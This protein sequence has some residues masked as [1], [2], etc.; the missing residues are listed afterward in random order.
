MWQL[1]FLIFFGLCSGIVIAGGVT[2]L[3]IGLS[4]VPR[5]A[6][7]TH[8]ARSI[9]LYEDMTFAGIFLG[10]LFYLF[11]LH[12]PGGQLMLILYGFFSGIF[13]GGWILALAEIADV[14]PVFFRKIRLAEGFV[15][16]IIS[17][18]LGKCL[19]SLFFYYFGQQ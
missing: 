13:L 6:G 17:I 2:G 9:L 3:M 1:I 4:I 18:S 14:F 5:Y 11:Q 16:V 15:P 8:S 12:I 10:N 7:I 19:G